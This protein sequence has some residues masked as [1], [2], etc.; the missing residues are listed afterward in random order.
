MS[1]VEIRQRTAYEG[2]M[3]GRRGQEG[4]LA[5]L[6]RASW[7]TVVCVNKELA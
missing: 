4:W 6:F 2:Q 7:S 5:P 3:S 1:G